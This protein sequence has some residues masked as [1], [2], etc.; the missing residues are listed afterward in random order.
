MQN[1]DTFSV[2][3]LTLIIVAAV[4]FVSV[5]VLWMATGDPYLDAYYVLETFFDVQNTAAAT[6]LATIAFS[7]GSGELLPILAVVVADNLS[8]LLIVSFILAAVLDLLE[9]ANVEEFINEIKAHALRNHVIICGYNDMS[10][11]LIKKLDGAR[12]GYIVVTS[13]KRE[14]Q[15]LNEGKT[16]NLFGES[17]DASVL[18]KAGIGKARAVVFTSEDSVEN[19]MSAL[20]AR[21]SSARVKVMS[22]LDNEH[23]RRKVYGIGVDLAVIPEQLA[24]YEMGEY[25]SK[26]QGA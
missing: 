24:G 5:A 21:R 6:S 12:I 2:M 10:E 26:V 9:Y 19:V 25:V 1:E 3:A 8:R 13:D 11:A 23:V 20:A 22:R 15:E 7:S 16:L 4:L 14:N 17:A 18:E